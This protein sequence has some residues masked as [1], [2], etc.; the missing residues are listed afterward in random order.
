MDE[1]EQR[2]RDGPSPLEQIIECGGVGEGRSI[3]RLLEAKPD[4]APAE[5]EVQAAV[6]APPPADPAEEVEDG[7]REPNIMAES[8]GAVERLAAVSG[9]VVPPISEVWDELFEDQVGD[10]FAVEDIK[11]E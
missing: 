9:T 5:Q 7:K 8:G 1:D 10:E 4:D 2:Y 11:I 3:E 6:L